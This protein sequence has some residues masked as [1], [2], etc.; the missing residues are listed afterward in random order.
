MPL[1]VKAPG[2]TEGQ[3][4]DRNAMLIDVVPTIIDLLDIEVDWDLDGVSLVGPPRTDTNKP[5]IYSGPEEVSGQ[6]G[7]AVQTAQ[8]N[9][10]L[11]PFEGPWPT[12]ARVGPF[13]E[14]VGRQVR[15]L[16]IAGP[17]ALRWSLEESGT[18]AD[19]TP[20]ADLIPLVLHGTTTLAGDDAPADGLVVLN[21]TVAG[22]L[23]LTAAE[24]EDGERTFTALIDHSLLR[25]GANSVQILFPESDG[26]LPSWRV[27]VA[28]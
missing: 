23:E 3:T 17:S 19:Y 8:R 15:D 13:A 11:I 20:G 14:L 21:G 27:A 28:A 5:V 12:V 10:F 7:E 9:V 2:Q 24:G 16:R 22:A 6:F 18:L 4:D 1:L 26:R 25:V